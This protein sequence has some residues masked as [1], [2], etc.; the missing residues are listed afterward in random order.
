MNLDLNIFQ[1]G[2]INVVNSSLVN[3]SGDLEFYISTL[4][5]IFVSTTSHAATYNDP[6]N[7]EP[8]SGESKAK[9]RFSLMFEQLV[10]CFYTNH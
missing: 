10:M 7:G 1:S 4:C 5:S 9:C 6:L 3:L 2:F 8:S